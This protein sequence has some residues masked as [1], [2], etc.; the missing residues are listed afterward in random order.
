MG[1]E[2]LNL[3]VVNNV[4]YSS[5][6]KTRMR[7]M[8]LHFWRLSVYLLKMLQPVKVQEIVSFWFSMN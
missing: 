2:V 8:S 3:V 4:A 6:I 1:A 5:R 7:Y